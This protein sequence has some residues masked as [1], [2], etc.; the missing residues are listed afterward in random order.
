MVLQWRGGRTRFQIDVAAWLLTETA[1]NRLREVL[2]RLTVGA[3][4][5][6]DVINTIAAGLKGQMKSGA[7]LYDREAIAAGIRAGKSGQANEVD[8]L[9]SQHV[10]AHPLGESVELAQA[11][12]IAAIY[13]L[14]REVADAGLTPAKLVSAVLGNSVEKTGVEP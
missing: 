11:I 9:V 3:W 7:E 14:P 13:G 1:A 12:L 8:S 5:A 4:S 6:G 2:G 10:R